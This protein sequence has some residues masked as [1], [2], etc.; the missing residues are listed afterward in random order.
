MKPS[1]EDITACVKDMRDSNGTHI[2]SCPHPGQEIEVL[3]DGKADEMDIIR[4]K[5]D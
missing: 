4:I 1:G 2:E 5:A 3:F